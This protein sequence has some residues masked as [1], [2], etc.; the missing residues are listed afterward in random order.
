MTS[1]GPLTIEPHPIITYRPRQVTRRIIIHDSHTT[2]AP[3]ADLATYL[4]VLG[5][6]RG[7][8][9]VGYHYVV[10]RDGT[11]SRTRPHTTIGSH[12]PGHNH[13][14]IGI[15]LGVSPGDP[16]ELTT[17]QKISLRFIITG[18]LFYYG[19]QVAIKGHWEVQKFK[20]RPPCP[21]FDM[22]A[23]RKLVAE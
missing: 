15:C 20:G 19:H 21:S 4:R 10:E 12:A 17:G 9:E 7:L 22:D 18:L 14:S 1:P 3:T 6:T 11:Y 2:V 16:S 8:L 23:I 13:D 5:R